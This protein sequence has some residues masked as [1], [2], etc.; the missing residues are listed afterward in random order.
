MKEAFASE[1][2]AAE[3][4]IAALALEGGAGETVGEG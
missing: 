1:Q 2:K 3:C 4:F